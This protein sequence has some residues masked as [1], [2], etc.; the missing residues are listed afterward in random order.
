[1][2]LKFCDIEFRD[3]KKVA[4]SSTSKNFGF[5]ALRQIDLQLY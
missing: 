4:L 3:E 5:F 1:L 2:S